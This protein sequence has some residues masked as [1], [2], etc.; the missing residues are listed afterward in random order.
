MSRFKLLL[1]GGKP[2]GRE[3]KQFIRA[4]SD[5]KTLAA[6]GGYLFKSRLTGGELHFGIVPAIADGERLHHYDIDV[7]DGEHLLG[8]LSATGEFSVLFKETSMDDESRELWKQQYKA[9]AVT[10]LDL[11]Y[12]G[13]GKLDWI[14]CKI[15]EES[16]LFHPIPQTLADIAAESQGSRS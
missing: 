15:I 6:R 14:S 4:L 13:E 3:L 12:A 2:S 10:L 11:G 7:P 1:N 16:E 5:A 8:S 9:L